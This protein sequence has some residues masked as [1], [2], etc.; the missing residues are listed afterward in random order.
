MNLHT[1]NDIP[2]PVLAG[3]LHVLA[4]PLGSKMVSRATYLVAGLQPRDDTID[5]GLE[6]LGFA[7][8]TFGARMRRLKSER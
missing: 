7:A 1:V 6:P 8:R 4:S 2:P 5:E 3:I